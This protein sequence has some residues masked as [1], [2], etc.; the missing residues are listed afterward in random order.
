M[1]YQSL[2]ST[3]EYSLN[4]GLYH[5][6]SISPVEPQF[7]E[8]LLTYPCTFSPELLYTVNVL[9]TLTDC[10]G[11]AL[12]GKSFADF[13]LAKSASAFDVI[14]NEILFM[15][16]DT[17]S[18]FIELYNRS[19]K[20]ID[21]AT[22]RVKLADPGT[23][24]IKKTASLAEHPFILFP[25]SY[26]VLTRRAHNLPHS[27]FL[28]NPS[29]ILELPSLFSLPDEEGVLVLADSGAQTIDELHYSDH[30]HEELLK[31]LHGVSLERVSTEAPANSKENWHS[32]STTSGYSTPGA[33]NSQIL[34]QDDTWVVTVSPDICSPDNDGIDDEVTIHLQLNEPGWKA[35]IEIFDLRGRKI[36]KVINNGLLGTEEYFTWDGK[37]EEEKTVALGIYIIYGELFNSAG[38]RKKFKKVIGLAMSI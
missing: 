13:A 2:V 22:L 10:S 8:V 5:P 16:C 7:K 19:D 32:A 26:M 31:D 20:V 14:F 9:S 28:T 30:M 4:H 11:N 15:S 38:N 1:N 6:S 29:V 24:I 21:L 34:T 35:T 37:D 3:Q 23:G 18:E 36:K 17:L 27:V 12:S 33:V 25:G